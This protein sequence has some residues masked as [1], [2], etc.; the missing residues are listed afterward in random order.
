[1]DSDLPKPKMEVDWSI[2]GG[3]VFGIFFAITFLVVFWAIATAS[4]DVS[5]AYSAM[6]C[7]YIA[8]V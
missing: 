4:K 3:F 1:M 8:T 7:D 2:T 6:M 5:K